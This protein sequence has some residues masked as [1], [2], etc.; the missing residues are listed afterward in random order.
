MNLFFRI[1]WNF[2][3]FFYVTEI[4]FEILK[5][6]RNVPNFGCGFIIRFH[7]LAKNFPVVWTNSF[8]VIALNFFRK[9]YFQKCKKIMKKF[10][11]IQ[12]NSRIH[13]IKKTALSVYWKITFL[14]IVHNFLALLLCKMKFLYIFNIVDIFQI[15]VEHKNQL[16]FFEKPTDEIFSIYSVV[17]IQ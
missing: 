12:N 2:L 6:D 7:M 14:P 9:R 15:F 13:L 4:F 10:K 5:N 8:T 3:H 11:C 17:F 1:H 16:V